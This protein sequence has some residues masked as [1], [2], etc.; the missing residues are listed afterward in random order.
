MSGDDANVMSRRT[1][2]RAPS[3]QMLPR[4]RRRR[5]RTSGGQ[6]TAGS[7][8]ETTPSCSGTRR[9]TTGREF[10][11]HGPGVAVRVPNGISIGSA[12]LA[13]LADVSNGVRA[14]LSF[15]NIILKV[16]KTRQS[17]VS[18]TV[19]LSSGRGQLRRYLDRIIRFGAARRCV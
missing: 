3:R 14:A 9:L 15:K 18:R 1:S 16:E 17:A 7:R 10:I 19:L 13:R 12:A 8:E 5:R 6:T 2:R 11:A 4:R